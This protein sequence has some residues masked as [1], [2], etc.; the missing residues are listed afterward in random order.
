MIRV[1]ACT[2]MGLVL[3]GCGCYA[4]AALRPRR[5]PAAPPHDRVRL[6]RRER[7]AW[8]R[9]VRR[10]GRELRRDLAIA[11][12]EEHAA[13]IERRLREHIDGDGT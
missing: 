10:L 6:R 5:H 9:A 8:R 13:R 3:A 4:R 2:A 1:L 12:L 11:W 7:A